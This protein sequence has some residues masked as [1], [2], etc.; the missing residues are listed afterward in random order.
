M[1]DLRFQFHPFPRGDS[2]AAL[3]LSQEQQCRVFIVGTH[4]YPKEL[5]SS[6]A[7]PSLIQRMGTGCSNI[8]LQICFNHGHT[9][10]I[11]AGAVEDSVAEHALMLMLACA[12]N[13]HEADLAIRKGTWSRLSGMSLYGKT[14]GL[15]GYGNIARKLATIAKKAFNV[16]IH[17]LVRR[18][19]PADDWVDVFTTDPKT[20]FQQSDIISLHLPETP[21]TMGMVNQ[22][23]LAELNPGSILVNTARGSL[24]DEDALAEALLSGHLA[25]AGLDVFKN[26][27][28]VPSGCHDFRKINNLLM[29]PHIAS[30]SDQSN[31]RMIRICL[32]NADA[33]INTGTCPNENRVLPDT[34]Q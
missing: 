30:S 9:V 19:L 15:V 21:K 5:F 31:S 3:K 17:A 28:Y 26:E 33:F 10:A 23:L 11:T 34:T 1:E 13:A 16:R 7:Y 32:G 18:P 25:G 8:P 22:Q 2:D 27:P 4:H 14:L 20:L 24:I 29:T 6:L 12:R